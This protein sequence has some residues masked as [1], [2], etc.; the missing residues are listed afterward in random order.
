LG[1]GSWELGAGEFGYLS[2]GN[3]PKNATKVMKEMKSTI[4]TI[5]PKVPMMSVVLK[6]RSSGSLSTKKEV[7]EKDGLV[8]K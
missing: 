1:V 8:L 2:A 5:V 6:E 4:S 3:L 7:E